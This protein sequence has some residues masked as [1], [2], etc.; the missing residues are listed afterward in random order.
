MVHDPGGY[1]VCASY[2]Q[3]SCGKLRVRLGGAIERRLAAQPPGELHQAGFERDLR[4]VAE[5]GARV[6]D[7]GE[8][9]TDVTDTEPAGDL[10][11]DLFGVEHGTHPRGDL[12]H[13]CR[14]AAADVEA[15][16]RRC[17]CLEREAQRARDVINAD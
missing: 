2:C 16:S 13:R 3:T 15:L 6:R 4:L 1:G 11:L 8:A 12:E 5:H 17:R 7:V 9:V 14:L 10:G